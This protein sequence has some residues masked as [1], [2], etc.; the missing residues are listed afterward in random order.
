MRND[1]ISELPESLITQILLWLPTKDSIKTSVLSTRWRNLW[2]NE[3][4][5][6]AVD[7][8]IQHLDFETKNPLLLKDLMPMNIYK[9]KTLVSLKLVCVE[10][11]NPKIVVSLPCL[12]IMHL[13]KIWY[14]YDG[15]LVVEKLI[16]GCPVL[17]DLTVVRIHDKDIQAMPLLHVRSL[18]LKIFRLMFNLEMTTRPILVEI[19]A[20]NL[21]YISFKARQSDKIMVKNLSSLFKIDLD[22]DFGSSSLEPH[23]LRKRRDI[24][25]DVL[26]GISSVRHMI[27]SQRTLEVI[28]GYSKLGPIPKFHHLTHLKAA[29]SS[30]SLQLLLAFLE[31]CPNLKNLILDFSVSTEP[32]QIDHTNVPRCITSTLE[33]IEIN[34]LIRKEATGIKLVQYFLENSPILKKLKLNFTFTY[35]L[36]SMTHLPLDHIFKMYR[37][38][39]KRSRRCKVIIPYQA[40]A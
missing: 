2:L 25:R 16:S 36:M 30:T 5:A 40:R 33:C 15:P 28:H 13:E 18:T 14:G 31:S 21:K 39:R 6:T 17:E 12:K 19:D 34:K 20:P 37:T 10:L 9:S 4:I 32:E 8:G 7:S 1:I 3:W 11:E 23:D 24:I 38:S 26:T 22:T 27:I 35:S 29:F